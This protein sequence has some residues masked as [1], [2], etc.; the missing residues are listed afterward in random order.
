MHWRLALMAAKRE[1]FGLLFQREFDRVASSV[2]PSAC[3]LYCALVSLRNARTCETAPT[4]IG[5]LAQKTHQT[6]RTVFRGLNELEG[7]GFITKRK[8]G[9][10]LVFGFPL[11]A[12]GDTHDTQTVTP[13]TPRTKVKQRGRTH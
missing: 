7:C 4:G 3:V 1:A 5:L 12:K 8:D 6:R 13:M 9:K 11:I 10:R 2:L